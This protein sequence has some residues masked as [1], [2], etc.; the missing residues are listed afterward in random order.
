MRS[1]HSPTY[2]YSALLQT[3]TD[4]RETF[5]KRN[6]SFTKPRPLKTEIIM[7]T[8]I[9]S[10]VG[11]L[12]CTCS[13][14][15]GLKLRSALLRLSKSLAGPGFPGGNRC[16]GTRGARAGHNYSA[17]RTTTSTAV[18]RRPVG[19][20][21]C[22]QNAALRPGHRHGAVTVTASHDSGGTGSFRA[23]TRATSWA[24]RNHAPTSCR[25]TSC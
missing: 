10:F 6:A 3:R 16:C 14:F 5:W 18:E 24:A 11:L 25:T 23:G 4:T 15:P 1:L 17:C 20:T 7:T 2:P 21:G 22:V 19:P 12:P 13:T 9:G 8:N